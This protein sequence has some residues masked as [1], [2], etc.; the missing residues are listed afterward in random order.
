[1][2][3]APGGRA[4]FSVVITE[5]SIVVSDGASAA[6]GAS[7]IF[8][9]VN[10]STSTAKVSFLGRLSAPIAPNHVGSL[11][12]FVTR[13]GTFPIVASS[14]GHRRLRTFIVY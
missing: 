8:R 9:V 7:V 6:R 12:V 13:R 5:R 2:T 14:S 10:R 4:Y 1:M 11:A 3:T